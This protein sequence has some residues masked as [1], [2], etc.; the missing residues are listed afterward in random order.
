MG[1]LVLISRSSVLLT[2]PSEEFSTGTTPKSAASSCTAWNTSSMELR[3]R[4]SAPSRN[5]SCTAMCV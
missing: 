3:G 1:G 2:A 5:H 4:P